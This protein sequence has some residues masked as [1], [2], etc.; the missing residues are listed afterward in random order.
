MTTIKDVA[1]L[2][3]VS[4]ATVSRAMNNSGYVGAES[5]RKIEVAIAELNFYPNE[6]A[7]SLYQKKSKFVGLLL[8]D[9]SNPFFPLLAKGVE[10]KMNQ[11]G[12]QLILGNVQENMEKEKEYLKTFAQNNVAGVLSAING[13]I[14]KL[15]GI[16]FV[17][18]DRVAD[19][20][21]YGVHSNDFQGGQLAATAIA[22]RN[23]HEIVVLVGPRNVPGSLERLRGIEE[24]L[25]A[26]KRTYQLLE[27]SSFQFDAT[28]ETTSELFARFPKVDSVI[29]SNDVHALA[30]LQE[31]LRRGIKIPEELQIIGYDDIPFSKML[32]PSLATISQP[33]YEIGYQGAELLCDRIEDN[34]I[35]EKMIQL[36]VKLE[37]RESL[38]KKE[39]E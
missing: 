31:A 9:I 37:V 2:A 27:T 11:M 18:L 20:E 36:P 1:R 24:V 13:G 28:K 7:R 17:M 10:D 8:P 34:Y 25:H 33:A 29:A 30:I 16:P 4:V 12:Y 3:G 19:E 6:V 23:P 38:R 21:E 5:R 22:E 15:G 32:F 35:K 14:N 39:I 26:R